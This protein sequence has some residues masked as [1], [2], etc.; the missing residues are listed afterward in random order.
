MNSYDEIK[1]QWDKRNVPPTPEKGV[2]EIIKKFAV[3]LKKQRIS[4]MVLGCTIV[5]LIGFFFYISAY[6]HIQLLLGL[7]VMIGSLLIRVLLE[8]G[9]TIKKAKLPFGSSM[10]A[11]NEK[12]IAYYSARRR[13]HYYITPILFVSY[14]LGFVWL[15]PLFRQN[16]SSGMYSYILWS[17]IFIFA[18]L[19]VLIGVQIKR[20]LSVLKKLKQ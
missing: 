13:I 3:I 15:L 18:V 10:A 1:N 11:Y 6:S 19:A 16:L 8:Y 5:V 20:E 9:T 2:E 4:Q 12:L 17:S 7:S 14:V